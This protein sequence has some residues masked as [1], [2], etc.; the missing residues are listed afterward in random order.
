MYVWQPFSTKIMHRLLEFIKRIYVLLLFVII[1]G[2]AVWCY[3]TATPYT[4]SK[5]LARTNAVGSMIS[6]KVYDA[7][8]FISL[9][10]QNEKLNNRVAELE[11][12][13]EQRNMLLA[14]L[15]PEDADL[16]LVDS[17]DNKFIY[18]PAGVVSMTTNR[19]HNYIVLDKGARHGI[20][21][22]MGVMTPNREFIGTIESC[23]DE[24]SIVT[25]LL[26]TR[27]KIGGRLVDNE[28]V[29]SVYWDGT[30]QYEVTAIEISRY[31][32]PSKGMEVNVE[33][34]RLP[35][36]VKIGSIEE[37]EINASKTAYSATLRIAADMQRLSN[38]LI[39]ENADQQQLDQ[40][41]EQFNGG[42]NK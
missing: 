42:T 35:L 36:G 26:N 28:Y 32:E 6:N 24:Y 41:T 13:L 20:T 12:E 25:P 29:C 18:H 39:I 16:T 9:P 17:L 19:R 7:S 31:A 1:E 11:M 27:F 8:N 40:L 21:K 38:V 23:S 3:A 33:S 14:E 10:E 22:N 37:Y 15:M 2:V 5:I 30:S 4:E 34:D